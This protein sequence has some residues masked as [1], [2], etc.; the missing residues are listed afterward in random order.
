MQILSFIILVLL[1]VVPVLLTLINII[2]LFAK[3][4]IKENL[5]DSL[6]F[7]LGTILTYLLYWAW[8][9]LDYYKPITLD[10]MSFQLHAPVASTHMITV[11]VLS[12]IS[13]IGYAILRINKTRLTPLISVICLS[14]I[15]VGILLSIIYIIQLSKNAFPHNISAYIPFDVFYMML[16]PLN[17]IIC[18]IRLIRQVIGLHLEKLKVDDVK[19][20]NKFL[21]FCQQVLVRST[22]WY[23]LAFTVMIPLLLFLI[24]I[25]VLF[26]Q[27]P[28]A[29]VRAFTETSD[30]TL[31]QKISP[32]PIQYEGHYLCTVALNGHRNI[33][34][35]IRV[36]VRHDVKI[37]VNRQL[38]VANAFEQLIKEN[39]PV[40]HKYVRY[41]YDKYGYP[42]SKHI[43]TPLRA[44][45]IYFAMKPLEWLF[46]ITL[47][48]FDEK[49]ENRIAMQYTDK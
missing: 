20:R 34:K 16:F 46:L 3:N 38:C 15:L 25:L 39:I 31:S 27:M 26:G 40:F 6:T 13:I 23:T 30:W 33:V 18:S 47:Y 28:D 24:I 44:D 43:S 17:Y 8:E 10:G 5:A 19:Y 22:G 48:L 21:L 45:I 9:P 7:I 42:I 2:N 12:A 11:L 1:Y 41:I 32:P 36:G 37:L 29:V 49:P 4:R 35:P 14:T